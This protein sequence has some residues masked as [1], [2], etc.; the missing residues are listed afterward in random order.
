MVRRIVGALVEVGKGTLG[1]KDIKLA[2]EDFSHPH[3]T[4]N[5]PACGLYLYDVVY[6]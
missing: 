1:E 2:L 6:A 4:K 3:I 5:M